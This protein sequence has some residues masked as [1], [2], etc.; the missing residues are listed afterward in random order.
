M[1]VLPTSLIRVQAVNVRFLEDDTAFGTILEQT[2]PYRRERA[3]RYR[4]RHDRNLS[5]GASWALD[6]LLQGYG[7]REKEM[8][9]E[10]GRNGKPRLRHAPELRFNLSHAGDYAVC[11]MGLAPLGIDVEPVADFDREVAARCLSA[12]ELAHLKQLPAS[13]QK[14]YF[15]RLWTLKESLLKASGEGLTA[16]DGFPGFVPDRLPCPAGERYVGF[17]LLEFGWAGYCA[18]LCIGAD[19]PEC[20]TEFRPLIASLSVSH[21]Q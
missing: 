4:F 21:E 13:E 10:I 9:Y 6:T 14:V 7:L 5:L 2:S 8:D 17:R 16:A 1:T 19:V 3:L 20:D 11:A 15:T 12:A 18:A